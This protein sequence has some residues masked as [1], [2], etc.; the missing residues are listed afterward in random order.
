M[1]IGRPHIHSK[2]LNPSRHPAH[3]H[4]GTIALDLLYDAHM[5]QRVVDEAISVEVPGIVEE[6]QIAG[7]DR[8]AIMNPPVLHD[9]PVDA[10]D[11]VAT[12]Q[13]PQTI[14]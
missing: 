4:D 7:M 6:H 13:L 2:P 8:W 5:R 14:V 1:S 9:V 10:P 12:L 11:A 3:E